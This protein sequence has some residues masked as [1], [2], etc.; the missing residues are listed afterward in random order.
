MTDRSGAGATVDLANAESLDDVIAAINS[1]GVGIVAEVNDARNGLQIRDTSGGAGHLVVANADAT[2]TADN[3]KLAVDADVSQQNSGSLNRQ[4][5][6]ERTA[7]SQLNGGAGV[8][9]GQISI[10]NSNGTTY[11]VNLSSDT[12][13]TV[14]DV[15]DKINT[16]AVG[17]EASLNE[18]GDGI[19]LVDTAGG[20]GKLRVDEAG[21]HTARDLRLLGEATDTQ[22][23]GETKSA[24]DGSTTFKIHIGPKDTLQDVVD[25]IDQLQAG[26]G[27]SIF[28][29]GFSANPFRL[30]LTSERSG[31]AGELL[32]DTSQ[33]G[34]KFTESARAQD[35]VLLLGAPDASSAGAVVASS[36][37]KFND[38][39]PG[40]SLQ[41]HEASATPVTIQ[42]N[43]DST[44]LTAGVKALV[45]NY[46]TLRKKIDSY[47]TYDATQN[48]KGDLLGD[49]A[50]LRVESDLN[51]LL[52]GRFFGS[53]SIG[54]LEGIGV[55]IQ[56][57]GTLTF[58]SS[59]L[60]EKFKEDPDSVEKF[61]TADN[62]G[63]STKLSD[64][65]EELAGDNNSLLGSRNQSLQQKIDD[66]QKKVAFYNDQL[67]RYREQQLTIFN[68][69]E[70]AIAKI[71]GNLSA[72]T[73]IQPLAP[74]QA[75]TTTQ[76]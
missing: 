19:L 59:V 52:S 49:G 26:V 39:I 75:T 8:S 37:G 7:L 46:N 67:D 25:A 48:K 31:K 6:S 35:A 65:I 4:L 68:N 14:G 69:L 63:F 32:V 27:A 36:T 38:L 53:D 15:I 21:G 20:V 71:Q 23:D 41:V 28:N 60:S 30:S 34:F 11:N 12:I 44:N 76:F 16:V 45:D 43:S 29:D 9:K 72:L 5:V 2:N 42:V 70:T 57:D 58:D 10:T 61:F 62:N 13:Q 33:A 18:A 74:L 50:A 73:A 64:L 51:R 17:V 24:I 56:K 66:N 47:T 1:A 54:S 55:T 22:V 3:L 40:L